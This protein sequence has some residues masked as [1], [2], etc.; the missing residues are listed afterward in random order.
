MPVTMFT[1]VLFFVN[2]AFGILCFAILFIT[3]QLTT[4]ITFHQRANYWRDTIDG[5]IKELFVFLF[6]VGI[7]KKTAKSQGLC[8]KEATKISRLIVKDFVEHWYR[9]YSDD[10][11]FPNDILLLLEHLAAKLE[12]RCRAI[13]IEELLAEII[14]LVTAQLRAVSSS[15]V[16]EDNNGVKKLDVQSSDCVRQFETIHLETVHS[17]LVNYNS[18]YRHIKNIID[19][20]LDAVL[21]VKYKHCEGGRLFVREV[22]TCRVILPTINQLCNPNFLNQAIVHLFSPANPSRI[23]SVM[24]QIEAENAELSTM[25]FHH[26][27]PYMSRTLLRHHRE[28]DNTPRDSGLKASHNWKE[29]SYEVETM[30]QT[31][32][33]IVG[34]KYV[35]NGGFVGYIVQVSQ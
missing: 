5:I 20:L 21:P 16:V 27:S 15:A 12:D 30:Y 24:R 2:T 17:S 13:N 19:L 9:E 23:A 3:V 26:Y 6:K 14:P 1:I 28:G 8:Q 34:Y 18:E 31:A 7:K 29:T 4:F 35:Q 32:I 10:K 33:S 25:E 11:E 22:L